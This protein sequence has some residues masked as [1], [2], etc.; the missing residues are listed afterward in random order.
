MLRNYVPPQ[1]SVLLADSYG[2][3]LLAVASVIVIGGL[4]VLW[5]ISRKSSKWVVLALAVG[6]FILGTALGDFRIREVVLLSGS[7][8]LLGFAGVI[9]GIFDYLRKRELID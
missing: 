5:F 8:Q 6:V 4:G 2:S 1:E 9:L 3:I 7:F